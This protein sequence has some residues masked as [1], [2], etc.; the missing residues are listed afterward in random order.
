MSRPVTNSIVR[1]FAFLMA[2]AVVQVALVLGNW[3]FA[4]G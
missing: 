1:M 3:L 4:I 2:L